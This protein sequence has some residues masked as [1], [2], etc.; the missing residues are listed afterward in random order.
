M[1]IRDT[2]DNAMAVR[3]QNKTHSVKGNSGSE[4]LE[5]ISLRG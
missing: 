3:C 5:K 2:S 1:D 4:M